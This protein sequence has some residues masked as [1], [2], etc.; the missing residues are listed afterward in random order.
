ML[1]NDDGG[2][3]LARTRNSSHFYDQLQ[4]IVLREQ[5]K[6]RKVKVADSD[7]RAVYQYLIEDER[8]A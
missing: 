1:L 5:I 4:D 7:V 2:G 6:V 3:F 8:K